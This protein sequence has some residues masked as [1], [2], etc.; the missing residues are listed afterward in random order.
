MNTSQ[1]MIVFWREEQSRTGTLTSFG[2]C[3][4]AEAELYCTQYETKCN[5]II[6]EVVESKVNDDDDDD[7][8]EI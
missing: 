5:K 7:D 3:K 4:A 2:R 8:H 6:K 1:K